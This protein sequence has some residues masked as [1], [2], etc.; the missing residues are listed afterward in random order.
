MALQCV[1]DSY[2]YIVVDWH[3]CLLIIGTLFVVFVQGLPGPPGDIGPEGIQGKQVSPL[4]RSLTISSS[5]SISSC[6]SAVTFT[7]PAKT[8][9]NKSLEV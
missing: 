6:T 7:F 3:M 5:L 4:L 9:L 1:L 8:G 2:V